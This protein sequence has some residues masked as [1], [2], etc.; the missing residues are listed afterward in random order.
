MNEQQ[1]TSTDELRALASFCKVEEGWVD[2]VWTELEPGE[3]VR[4]MLPCSTGFA[5]EGELLVLSDRRL[6]WLDAGG[7]DATAAPLE[8]VRPKAKVPRFS[9]LSSSLT[10]ELTSGHKNSFRF[11]SW[12]EDQAKV[13]AKLVK[14]HARG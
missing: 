2:R 9:F 7:S 14:E 5:A 12:R 4:S 8:M 11:E 10:V 6:F 1:T 13:L 3:T